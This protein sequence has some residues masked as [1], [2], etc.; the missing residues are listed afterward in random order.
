[1]PA[2]LMSSVCP[3]ASERATT[4]AP[5]FPPA[6]GRFSTITG[7]P[8]ARCSRSPT[9]LASTSASPPGANGA[10]IF[11][12]FDGYAPC[13]PLPVA[14]SAAMIAAPIIRMVFIRPMVMPRVRTLR[15]GQDP[16][17]LG[18]ASRGPDPESLLPSPHSWGG[19][20]RTLVT[21][22]LALFFTA[23]AFAAANPA[24]VGTWSAADVQGQPLL[25]EFAAGGTGKANGQPIKWSTLGGALFVQQQNGQT[26]S[27]GF[28]VEGDKLLVYTQGQAQPTTLTKGSAAYDTAMKKQKRQQAAAA[29]AAAPAK[30]GGQSSGNG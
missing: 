7:C 14:P 29:S 12:A 21:F 8:S 6:P 13:A 20:M 10:T 27:Y 11:T 15:W 28:K 5:T 23:S 3:S 1:M 16:N 18:S 19:T 25:V 17:L 4:S 24:L 22:A 9:A 2:E 30:A 26:A